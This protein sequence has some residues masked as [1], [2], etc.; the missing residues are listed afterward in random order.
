LH[1]V[2]LNGGAPGAYAAAFG[3]DPA[4]RLTRCHKQMSQANVR[5]VIGSRQPPADL[6]NQGFDSG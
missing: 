3:N 5:I 4:A 6:F 1:R 2:L